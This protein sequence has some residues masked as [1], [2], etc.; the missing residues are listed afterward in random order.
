MQ[1]NDSGYIYSEKEISIINSLF[2]RVFFLD[3]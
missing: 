1:I 3:N 2:R